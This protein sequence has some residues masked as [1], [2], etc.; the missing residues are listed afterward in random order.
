MNA[1]QQSLYFREWGKARKALADH[2][3]A[4]DDAA[5]KALQAE[6]LGGKVKSSKVLTNEEFTK[7]LAKF[8]AWSEPANFDAQMHAEEDP[9]ARLAALHETIAELAEE[10]GINN[11]AAGINSYFKNW[12][13]ARTFETLTERELQQLRGIMERRAKQLRPAAVTVNP[14]DPF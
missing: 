13:A 6:A 9:A 14:N 5:R 1:K 8:K 3:R 11:G 12:L 4:N 7:V 2:G 10:C